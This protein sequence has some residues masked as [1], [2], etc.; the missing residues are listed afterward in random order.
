MSQSESRAQAQRWMQTAEDD[1]EAAKSLMENRF[2]SHA[3]FNAQQSA[4]KGLKAFWLYFG[5]DPWGHSVQKLIT[6]FPGTD[7]ELIVLKEKA[8]SLDRF[9]IT[10]RCPDSLP[11]M[12]REKTIS[13]QTQK[14]Q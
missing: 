10:T 1:I 4:E 9:Y 11:D 7:S 13:S 3:C 8:A 5:E 14:L 2:Y 6:T 12:T